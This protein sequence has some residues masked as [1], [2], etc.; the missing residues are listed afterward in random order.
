MK[1]ID[2]FR[3]LS[4]VEKATFWLFLGLLVG[5][6]CTNEFFCDSNC[7]ARKLLNTLTQIEHL[8]SRY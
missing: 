1:V 5:Y 8:T 4:P 3:A 2:R 6:L 7:Q